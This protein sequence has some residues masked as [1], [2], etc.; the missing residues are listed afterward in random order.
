LLVK[1]LRKQ[2]PDSIVREDLKTL[3]ICVQRHAAS[4]SAPRKDASKYRLPGC[5]F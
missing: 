3:G 1:N 4:L 5:A 2:M